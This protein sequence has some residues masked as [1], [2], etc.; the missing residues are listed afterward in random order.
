MVAIS[1]QGRLSKMKKTIVCTI[2]ACFFVIMQLNIKADAQTMV[3]SKVTQNKHDAHNEN[4]HDSDILKKRGEIY[5]QKLISR[6]FK[7]R[8]HAIYFFSHFK[9]A[10]VNEKTVNAIIELFKAEIE[11]SKIFADFVGKGGTADNLPKDIAYLNSEAYGMY[12]VYLCRLVG[13][14]TDKNLLPLLIKYCPMPE[15]LVNY[16]DDVVEPFVKALKSADNPSEKMNAI[17]VLAEMLKPKKEGY[18]ASGETRNKIKQAL[19]Q[20]ISDK[21]RLVKSVAVK[22]L[23]DS[24]DND[25][26]PI[27]E[28][29]AKNDSDHFEKKDLA[30]G[31][32]KTRYPVREEAEKAL[33]KI[34][35]KKIESK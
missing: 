28:N 9:I 15:V 12:H 1:A 31:E 17:F 30:T 23:G 21:D 22:A 32:L 6:D 5:Y 25:V 33:K 16:G 14:S 7:D 11:Q 19:M 35:E 18:V 10:E 3:D 29:I 34:R 24:D 8:D 4:Y 2:T 13:Q 27:L 26:I 20:A